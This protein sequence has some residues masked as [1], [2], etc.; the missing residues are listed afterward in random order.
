MWQYNVFIDMLLKISIN[1]GQTDD[2]L[3]ISKM[4]TMTKSS[5]DTE[6]PISLKHVNI[7]VTENLY[8]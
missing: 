4:I 5:I 6:L 2:C 7:L 1:T 3:C 8:N